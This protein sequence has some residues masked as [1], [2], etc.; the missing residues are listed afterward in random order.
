MSYF[1]L[2]FA[3]FLWSTSFPVVKWG[4]YYIEPLPFVFFRFLLALLFYLPFLKIKNLKKIFQRNFILIGFF[5]AGGY[6]FQFIGQKYTLAGRASLFINMYVLWIPLLLY[7]LKKQKLK[8]TGIL[9]LILSLTGLFLLFYKSF[10]IFETIYSKGDF[11]TL[12]SSFSWAFYIIFAKKLLDKIN[13]FEFSAFVILLTTVFLTPFSFINFK[14]PQGFQGYYAIFHLA[15]FCTFLAYFLYHL[16]L[17]KTHEFT[18]SLFL[19]LE[20]IFAIILSFIFLN[21]KFTLFQI[22]GGISI[23]SGIFLGSKEN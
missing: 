20:V 4:L 15:F 12:L 16:G 10:G 9:A 23:L 7:F 13:P 14:S 2:F 3:A 19:L 8:K 17:S 11:L 18:S 6:V 1:Y 22:I 21:E 5:S